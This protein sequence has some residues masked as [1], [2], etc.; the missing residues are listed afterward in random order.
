[1]KKKKSKQKNVAKNLNYSFNFYNTDL[2]EENDVEDEESSGWLFGKLDTED[3]SGVRC[4][5]GGDKVYG[6]KANLH[7]SWCPKATK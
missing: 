7:S 2:D 5:C 4:E 6:I 1:M 3:E